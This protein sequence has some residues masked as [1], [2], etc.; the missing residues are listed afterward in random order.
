MKNVV[1][2]LQ[3]RGFIDQM[4]SEDIAHIVGKPI[5]VYVG[6]DPTSDSLH[7]G[8]LVGIMALAWFQKYG[9]TP[10]VILGG[11]TGRIGDPSGKSHE[12]PFL[13]DEIL[14]NNIESIASFFEHLFPLKGPRPI[15]FNNNDW[16]KN[17]NLIDFLRDIGKHFRL[18]PMLAKESV[19][20][21]MESEEGMSFTEFSYQILQAYDFYFLS[22]KGNVMLQMGGSDQWG[23]IT[24]GIELTRRLSGKPLYGLTWSLLTR[25]DGK[26][27][28][29]SEEGAI[30]LSA[31]KL[32]PYEFYQYLVRIPD[33]DVIR[34]MRMLT[35]MSMEEIRDYEHKMSSKG[36]IPNTAQKKLAE[37]VC[38]FI[39]K[40]EGLQLAL[41]VTEAASPGSDSK[42]DAEVLGQIANDM[43]YC[44]LS[45]EEFIEQKYIDIAC[46][47]GLVESKSEAQ[48]LIKNG[49]AYLNNQR[50]DDPSLRFTID[51][52]IDAKY[53]ILGAGKKKKI[54]IRIVN[55]DS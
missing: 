8:N 30:W 10:Y 32:S 1:N 23:N 33:A 11:A 54:L 21:R 12:R 9:H 3:E 6:F 48:R 4:S 27:F 51:H 2:A 16:F 31:D 42:L 28:G 35:F 38:R 22:Q 37:E 53:A 44:S 18:G 25:S 17:H 34:L 55:K 40:E 24:A 47:I 19:R 45:L 36:Y 14:Q 52:L 46:K 50:I 13:S 15:I 49:G 29:K 26:K 43:P 5:S 39:H 7:L 20:A 41:K